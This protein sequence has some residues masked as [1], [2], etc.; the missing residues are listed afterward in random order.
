METMGVPVTWNT[1]DENPKDIVVGKSDEISREAYYQAIFTEIPYGYA[2][3]SD[4]IYAISFADTNETELV[5][6]LSK[7]PEEIIDYTAAVKVVDEDGELI[8]GVELYVDTPNG[9]ITWNSSD[10]NPKKLLIGNSENIDPENDTFE[11]VV[12]KAP[13]GMAVNPGSRFI[14]DFSE[15][16]YCPMYVTLAGTQKTVYGDADVSGEVDIND[17]VV[18]LIHAANV[19]ASKLSAQGRDNADVY[20][21]GDGVNVLDATSVQKYLSSVIKDLPESYL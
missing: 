9:R 17:V 6:E 7:E 16:N 19:N 20:Q 11:I 1:S 13:E 4:S 5:M 3:A 10:E 14:I 18:I 2:D 15:R 8:D 12:T 21:R